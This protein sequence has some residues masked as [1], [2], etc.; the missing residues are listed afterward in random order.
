MI[1]I[2]ERQNKTNAAVIIDGPEGVLICK[3]E[4]SIKCIAYKDK[5]GEVDHPSDFKIYEK[6][7]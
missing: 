1:L 3:D 7:L 5:W 4:I 2:S 6:D